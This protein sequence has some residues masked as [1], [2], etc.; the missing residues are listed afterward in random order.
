MTPQKLLSLLTVSFQHGQRVLIKGAPGVG[1]SDLVAQAAAA[2][3]MDCIVMQPAVSDPTDFK[4][5]PALVDDRARFIPFGDLELLITTDRPTVCF[6]DDI[7]QAATSV[8]AAL[9]HLLQAR[10]IDGKR[11][12][13]TVVF[14][15]ATNDNKHLA[16]VTGLIEPVKSRFDTIVEL[17]TSIDDWTAWALDH[18]HPAELVAFLRFRPALLSAF[19]ATRELTNSPCPRTWAAVGRWLSV[20]CREL[21]VLGG[22]IGVAAA[23]E[24][25]AFLQ[26]IEQLPSIDAIIL[27]PDGTMTPK[28]PALL[29]AVS[30]ALARRCAGP[31]IGRVMRYLARLPKEFEVAAIRDAARL[32]GSKATNT[33]DFIRWITA[34][35]GIFS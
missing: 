24:L 29:Y 4:G 23:G 22:C 9:M 14:C 16:G 12:S 31:E 25:L 28:E 34:N 35:Q 20:D 5:M 3:A 11:I 2:R 17:E 19:R 8:Q 30:S 27:D 13:N 21:E 26:M 6:L 1:K 18:G 32:H 7:G 33:A 15:G 10:E